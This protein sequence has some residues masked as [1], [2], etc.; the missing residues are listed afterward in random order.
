MG[1]DKSKTRDAKNAAKFLM[2]GKIGIPEL[3]GYYFGHGDERAGARFNRV[4]ERLA[5][6]ARI[7]YGMDM[8]YLITDGTE[9]EWEELEVPSTRST[10]LM[11]KYEI[12]YKYQKEEKRDH[13]RNK[14][15]MFGVILGQ[16]K[17]G[18]K[19]LVK[20]DKSYRTLERN[21]DVV[22]LINL[23]RS[24]CY[25][26]DKK[27]Y[28]S[29][30]QQAQLRKTVGSMQKDGESIQKFSVN[31]I[32][33]V[34]AFEEQFGPLLPTKEMY[35][36][37][38]MTRVVHD[39]EEECSETYAET[40]LA[41]EDEIQI[42][43]DKFVACLF[44][45]GVDRKRYKDAIDEMNND[46]LRHGKEY[47]ASVQ[48]MVVWLTKR[49]GGDKSQAKEDDATDGVTSFAQLDRIACNHCQEKGHFNWDCPKATTKQRENYKRISQERSQARF[50]DDSSVGS[51]RSS[52]SGRSMDSNGSGNSNGSASGNVRSKG[53]RPGTPRRTSRRGVF[54]MSNFAFGTEGMRS[55]F[56]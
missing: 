46:Y 53:R 19:D 38:E 6:Y 44:L 27:R 30:T 31:F 8:Y 51:D 55:A 45:A 21:G 29:W 20:S 24:L 34:K 56:G 1:K 17:E 43:R 7:E 25:G 10:A 54:E 18:T 49:R 14:E 42:A 37:V 35:K 11:R 48:A 13:K 47:P 5:D 22:E 50:S 40:V 12:D 28:I 4:I 9:P 16:C 2:R 26:T 15:K 41:S 52:N 39:G 23:I 32:E 33:Q 3:E 36:V